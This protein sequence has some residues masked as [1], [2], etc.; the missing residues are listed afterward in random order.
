M[1]LYFNIK[2]ILYQMLGNTFL[3]GLSS[4]GSRVL[5]FES[6]LGFGFSILFSI[7]GYIMKN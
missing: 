5:A 2:I 4:I 7:F 6:D 3:A 1:S